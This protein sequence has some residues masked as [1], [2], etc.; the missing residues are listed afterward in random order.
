VVAGNEIRGNNGPGVV[1]F[2]DDTFS[3][4]ISENSIDENA[5]IGIDLGEDG[6]TPNHTGDAA[7][8]NHFQNYPVLQEV[9]GLRGN[10]VVVRGRL[11]SR[12]LGDYRIEVFANDACD[13]SGNGEGATFLTSIEVQT[14]L[15]GLALF[16]LDVDASGVSGRFITATAS[17]L[18]AGEYEGDTS[19]FSACLAA[20]KGGGS[21]LFE[22][23]NLVEDWP[24]GEASSAGEVI[25][26]L[27]NSVEPNVWDSIAYYDGSA[28]LQTFAN[29]PLPSFNTLTE[30]QTGEDY[31][32]FVTADAELLP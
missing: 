24:I 1:V 15:N 31:W 11:D 9:E 19:E 32:L 6:A 12:P 14:D 13:P 22:G 20:P 28:W 10:E 23:W 25:E 5:G 27:D 18:T 21:E 7:G 3:V 30:L 26:V 17:N 16:A 29:A 4:T 8:A 2:G